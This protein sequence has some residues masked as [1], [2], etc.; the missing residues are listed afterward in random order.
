M[1]NSQSSPGRGWLLQSQSNNSHLEQIQQKLR[2]GNSLFLKEFSVLENDFGIFWTSTRKIPLKIPGIFSWGF[3]NQHFWHEDLTPS[4]SSWEFSFQAA[5]F[6]PQI[7][8]NQSQMNPNFT[9]AVPIPRSQW[10]LP[11]W[12]EAAWEF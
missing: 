3:G 4:P 11:F 5:K 1:E 8:S 12:E 10:E 7:L 9:C 6:P 2:G